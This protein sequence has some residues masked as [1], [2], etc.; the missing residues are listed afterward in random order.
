M[1]GSCPVCRDTGFEIR[2]HPDGA[3]TAAPCVCRVQDRAERL[4]RSARIPRRYDHCS[5]ESFE[6]H[7][8]SH[9]AACDVAAGWVAR[10]PLVE[11]GLL[12]LGQP[13]TGKTHIAV[14]IARAVA[15]TKGG[16]VLFYEQRD[17]LKEIQAT[18]D[19]GSSRT[20]S[21]ILRRILDCE[22]LVLDDLGAGRTTAWARDVMHD[23]IGQR[24]NDRA[25]LILTSNLAT[26]EDDGGEPRRSRDPMEGLTLRDRLG[27]P[28]MS[29]LY[30]MCRIVV[31]EGGDYRRGVLHAR[32]HY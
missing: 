19:A 6:T 27:D 30:E 12:F 5:L 22:V 9:A 14:G 28:L 29:R 7:H 31:L 10:W 20:E 25:P 8:P 18:F 3:T 16:R 4:L 2:T 13:G 23:L 32:I 15:C 1:D 17:L 24:Y 26:G 11:H 21:D